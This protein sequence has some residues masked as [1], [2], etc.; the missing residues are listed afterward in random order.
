M[1]FKERSH[2]HHVKV[3]GE[4]LSTDVEAAASYPD[5]PA[6]IINERGYTKEPVFNVDKTAVHWENVLSRTLVR[7]NS[8][9]G[10]KEQ[11]DSLTGD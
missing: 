10:F 3:Q 2:L 1:R 9:P 11:A 7:E 8:M 4:G 5:D 6:K